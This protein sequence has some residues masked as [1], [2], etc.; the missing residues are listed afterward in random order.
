MELFNTQ[1][2]SKQL[3]IARQTV[4]K[5]ALEHNIGQKFGVDRLFTS[6]DIE[7]LRAIYISAPKRGRPAVQQKGA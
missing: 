1:Q 5:Y 4:Q 2:V 7:R 3:S 6:E